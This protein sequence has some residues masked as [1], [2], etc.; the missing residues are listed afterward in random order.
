MGFI[1]MSESIHGNC[2]MFP[3][4]FP[5]YLQWIVFL[6]LTASLPVLHA[7]SPK[8]IVFEDSIRKVPLAVQVGPPD[9]HRP[10]ISRNTLQPAETASEMEFEMVLKMR[11]FPELQERVGRGEIIPRAEMAAKYYPLESDYKLVADWIASQGFKIMRQDDNRLAI[12]A[13]SS[14]GRIQ[15]VLEVN[16]AR[17]TLEGRDYTSAVSAPSVPVSLSAM[18]LGI[19]GLQPHV[20]AH[21][22]LLQRQLQ[23][24]SLT[25]TNPPYLPSQIAQAYNANGLY[26]ANVTGS[27]QTIAIVIDTFPSTSDLTTFW[28]TYHVGQSINNIQFIQVI[29]GTLPAPSGE[30]SLDVEW[31]SSIAPGAHVRVYATTNL[32]FNNLDQAYQQIFNDVTAHPEYGIHQVSLSYGLGETYASSTQVTTDSQYFANLASAGV[33]IF[34]SSGD[35]GSTPGTGPAGDT[36]G[37]TQVETPASDPSVT[38]VGGTSLTLNSS[39]NV[40]TETAWSLSGGGASI[41]FNRPRWQTGNGVPA[42]TT[43][44]VPDVASVADPNTGAYVTLGGVQNVFGG[45]SWSS[46]TWAGFCALINQARANV[47]LPSVGLLGPRIYPLLGTTNF[48]DITSGSNGFSAGP[49]YDLVTGIG[50]PSVQTLAQTLVGVQTVPAVQTIAPGR[51]ATFTVATSGSA[52]GYQW[53]RMPTGSSTWSNLTDGGAYV[54]STTASLTINGATTATSGDQFQCLISTGTNIVTSVPPSVLVVDTPLVITTLAGQVLTS[55]TLNGSGTSAQFGYPSGITIDSSGDLYVADYNND[56]IRKVTPGGTVTTPYGQPGVA[57]SSNGTG[58]GALFNTP[59]AIAAD[60]SNNLYVA[61]SG[62]DTIR[63]ITPAGVVS[64]LAGK[65]GFT[66][67]RNGTGSFARFNNP[68]GIA[69][70]GSGNVYVADTNNQTIR[71]ITSAGAVSTLAGTA[72]TGGYADGTGASAKFNGPISVAVDSSGN[73]YVTDLYNY[74]AR[75]I[76]SAGVVTTPYGQVGAPGHFDGIGNGARFNAPIGVAVDG[77]NNLYITDSQ[78]PPTLTSTSSGNNLLRRITPAGVVST[79]AGTPGVT[80]STDGTGSGAQFYS[81]QAVATSSLGVVYL[82]DTF[83]QTIR[84]GGIAPMITGQPSNQAAVE[85]QTANFAVIASGIPTPACQWQRMASGSSSWSNLSDVAG[86]YGGTQTATLTVS[87]ATIAMSGDQFQCVVS[88]GFLPNAT[89]NAVTLTVQTGFNHWVSAYFDSQQ[90]A[91][92]AISGPNA[93]PQHDGIPNALKYLCDINPSLPMNAASYAALPVVGME[94][95]G[96]TQYLTL[97]Y[98]QN[99]TPTGITVNVQTSTDLQTWQTVA[100]DTIQTISTDPATG[101]PIIQIKVKTSNAPRMFVRLQ[102]TVS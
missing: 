98:R 64:T 92:P 29:A 5:S 84:A 36:S 66:G 77:S 49:G 22:H 83:N 2:C 27:G 24:N 75:K 78:V 52:I 87:N 35:G 17:V 86:T 39:G 25:G 14:V 63:K 7:A 45:T 23:P 40:S 58:N 96:G 9:P 101:D 16:F 59:N 15:Q 72:G 81:L 71:K 21:K 50:V 65:A 46:P 20:Q 8:S 82:A 32:A 93:T 56:T 53:Q 90:L 88:N 61:D 13:R 34:V 60:S 30:E 1:L 73:V 79:I 100:P 33:T 54:G 10:Y 37:P 6:L 19:N 85:G 43:R 48:R 57:G 3:K 55:G 76:T 11:N 68:Q 62:N 31:S 99:Q 67:A 91:S 94:T 26:S 42:G 89:S 44:T 51:N 70:D 95:D 12:F 69:V 80:G 4:R 41:Y 47:N 38:A 102:V 74:V 28:Q 18:L 97:T